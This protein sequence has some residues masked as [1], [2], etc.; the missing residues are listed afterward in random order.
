MTQGGYAPRPP[1]W[2]LYRCSQKMT[3]MDSCLCKIVK[4]LFIIF[5]CLLIIQLSPAILVTLILLYL[6]TKQFRR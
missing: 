3:W 5:I 2:N 1:T 4:F 6:I